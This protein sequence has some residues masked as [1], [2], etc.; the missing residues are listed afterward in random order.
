MVRFICVALLLFVTSVKGFAVEITE[1]NAELLN[2]PTDRLMEEGR[3]YYIAR[4]G[5]KALSRFLIVS[6]RFR[7]DGNRRENEAAIRALNNVGC[8]YKFFYYEYLP[9]YQYL[10][11]AYELC[12]SQNYDSFLPVVMVNLGDLLNDYGTIYKSE[13]MTQR[14]LE[15]FDKCYRMA[16]A[17]K[18]WELLTTAFFNIS[19]LNYDLDLSKYQTILSGDIPGSTP[20]IEFVRLQYKGIEAIQNKDYAKAR[21]YF[22][23][24]FQA[25]NTNWEPDRDIISINLN[26][27]YTYHQ[28]NNR[29]KEAEYLQDALAI[30]EANNMKDLSLQINADLAD[31]YQALG[32]SASYELYHR[33]YL[34]EMDD[35]HQSRLGNVAELKYLTD[36]KMEEQKRK[37][38]ALKNRMQRYINYG[39]LTLLVIILISTL[40]IWRKNRKLNS[41]NR[42][43]YDQ[44]QRLLQAEEAAAPENKYRHSNLDDTKKE[45]LVARIMEV[46]NDPSI[47][48]R[49]DFSSK[50]LARLVDS[51]TTYVSQVINESFGA[52]F[53]TILGN[54]RVK[55]ACREIKENESHRNLT[56]EAIANKVGFKSRTAF[57]NAFKR[58]VGLS[59]SEYLK[60]AG[61]EASKS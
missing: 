48:C 57:L 43:L 39:V 26:I 51:N 58:E 60:M 19:N 3:K 6:K 31:T 34:E 14:A 13:E 25:V 24:Q 28:E 42:N 54:F 18:D 32:D 8:V 46:M 21:E 47:I 27:A 41:T 17:N 37:E 38:L 20:D 15:L 2:M 61:Q 1:N 9:A 49:Q 11:K 45:K 7:Q 29:Q 23:R 30:A 10:A 40:L 22:N 4:D 56:I 52:S 50:E 33:Q 55:E 12:E 5:D 59:P 36:L 53:S 16:L 44:Y 35:I